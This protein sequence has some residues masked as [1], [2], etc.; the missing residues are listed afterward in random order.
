MT[1]RSKTRLGLLFAYAVGAVLISQS[2]VTAPCLNWEEGSWFVYAFENGF[3][4]GLVTPQYGYYAFWTSLATALGANAAPL[5]WAPF[6][7]T[8]FAF[9][10]WLLMALLITV[11]GSPFRTTGQQVLAL[12][13]V[14]FAFPMYARLHTHVAHFFFGVCA[15]TT[16]LSR[17]PDRLHAWLYRSVLLVAGMTGVVAIFFTP[18]FWYRWWR[19]R[20]D[21]ECLVQASILSVCAVVQLLVFVFDLSALEFVHGRSMRLASLDPI[22]FVTAVAN[23]SV[24]A[25]LL[26]PSAME[27]LGPVLVSGIQAG[28]SGWIGVGALGLCLALGLVLKGGRGRTSRDPAAGTLLLSSF[29]IVAGL[30]FV[31]STDASPNPRDKLFLIAGHSRYAFLPNVIVGFA[32]ILH[33]VRADRNRWKTWLYRGLLSWFVLCAVGGYALYRS[34]QSEWVR[35]CPRWASEVAA[36]QRGESRRLTINPPT[37]SIRLPVRAGSAR[38]F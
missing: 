20:A 34:Q 24:V 22:V 26:T 28:R 37:R 9:A 7:T 6:V 13:L 17:V 33:A 8:A 4:A 38:G 21:R 15:L 3:W 12:T 2:S 18:V 25:T 1:T 16:L 35:S 10:L 23:K 30:S 29:L 19:S 36:W 14:L 31:G 5:E 32:L 27:Q 11:P